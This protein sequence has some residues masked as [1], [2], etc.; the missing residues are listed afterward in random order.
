MLGLWVNAA[1]IILGALVGSRLRG[2]IPEKYKDTIGYALALCVLTIGIQGAIQTENMM[3]MII[4]AVVGSLIGEAL[5][6][7]DR[8]DS[9]GAWVQ[10]R[11]AKDDDGFSQGFI[12]ATLLYCVGSM[13][14]VGSIEAGLQNK[15][16]TLLAKAVLD[17]VSALILSSSMG[18][19]V[20][21]SALPLLA[22]Q[23]AIAL[24]A[25]LLGNFLPAEAI[26]EV[27]ATGSLLIIGLGFNMLGFSKARI[28]V[29]NMLPAILIPA[30]YLAARSLL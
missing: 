13:A 22:Y 6:L 23:G 28:C 29:G 30:V 15:P 2:G 25:M 18:M 10:K 1:T 19:G 21:L 26:A 5:R 7:E 9:L 17:G 24:L 27:S 16:D 14:V 11:L 12:S 20:A 8:L 4:S 3:L